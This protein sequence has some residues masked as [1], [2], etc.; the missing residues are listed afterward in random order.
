MVVAGVDG[1]RGG[2]IAVLAEL[3]RRGP[4]RVLAVELLPRLKDLLA[5]ELAPKV[6]ALDLP[7][8]LANHAEPGGRGCDRAARALLGRRASSVFSPPCRAALRARDYRAACR[9]NAASSPH[10]LMLSKQC[11]HLFPR[12]REA[13]SL[14]AG[15]GGELFH[16]SHPELAFLRLA[17]GRSLPPKKTA[18]GL[19]RR[20]ALLRRA[21]LGAVF[22]LAP[23]RGGW[24]E[25]DLL[26]AAAL[27]LTAAHIARGSA[28][29]LPEDPP[30]D[31][32]GIPM[33]VYY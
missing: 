3:P 26:D 18:T 9:A 4:P 17:G 14:V 5:R 10:G 2:W 7:L 13:D 15:A 33:R 31:A 16:E 23:A 27:V 6:V 28:H 29:C 19:A 1:A 22:T 12:L 32:R 20:R 21:S 24:R 25:D 8:G 11:W 30:E